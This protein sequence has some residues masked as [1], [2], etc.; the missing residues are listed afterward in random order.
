MLEDTRHRIAERVARQIEIEIAR[1]YQA[2]PGATGFVIPAA[3]LLELTH[4]IAYQAARHTMRILDQ[5]AQA[6]NN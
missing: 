1:D 5:A 6:P 3:T 4:Q 2:Q